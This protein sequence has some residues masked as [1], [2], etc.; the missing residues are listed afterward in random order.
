MSRI[1]KKLIKLPS[2]VSVNLENEK[3][4][5]KGQHG[6]LEQFIPQ[7]ITIE[8]QEN[9][10]VIKRSNDSKKTRS[11]H[12]LTRALVQNMVT[13][14]TEKFSKVLVV[15]GVGYRFQANQKLVTLLMGY[16]HP[17][18]LTIPA[19]LTVNIES[20]TKLVVTGINKEKVGFFASKIRE[21]RPP[22]PYKGKGIRYENEIILRKAGKTGK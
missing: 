4:I 2:S 11:F 5:I 1:G 12:G 6:A 14:V 20:P 8:K 22:E 19:D 21:V 15:D 3:I 10:L 13:G 17:V 18:E 7:G 16:S 9:N